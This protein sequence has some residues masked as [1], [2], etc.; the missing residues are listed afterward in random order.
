MNIFKDTMSE[1]TYGQI[2]K[3]VR[4]S[5]G[6]QDTYPTRICGRSKRQPIHCDEFKNTWTRFEAAQSIPHLIRQTNS[7][8]R[9]S[10]PPIWKTYIMQRTSIVL[11]SQRWKRTRCSCKA[12]YVKSA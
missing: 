3:L 1:M 8:C 9:C 10:T 2:E 11:V 12:S 6:G 5:G 4:W 7:A